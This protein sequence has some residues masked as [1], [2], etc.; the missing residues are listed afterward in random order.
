[1]QQSEELLTLLNIAAHGHEQMLRLYLAKGGHPNAVIHVNE[2]T[3]AP[4]DTS[5][6]DARA[7]PEEVKEWALL[8]YYCIQGWSRQI[9]ILLHANADPNGVE[10][11]EPPMCAAA[12]RGR[13]DIMQLL[14]SRGAAVNCSTSEHPTPLMFAAKSG[15]VSAVSW[16][17][18][19]GAD[20][21]SKHL[22]P[23]K[24]GHLSALIWAT[25]RGHLDV[26]QYLDSC[27]AALSVGTGA[28]RNTALHEA[29]LN[30]QFECLQYVLGTEAGRD[31]VHEW[32]WTGCTPLQVAAEMS[33]D[34]R[35]ISALIDAGSD[36]N[37]QD[38]GHDTPLGFAVFK[39]KAETV[40]VLCNRGADVM[41]DNQ[42]DG[43]SIV[44]QGVHAG[45][46]KAVR[47]LMMSDAWQAL[48]SQQRCERE[49]TL[50][51]DCTDPATLKAVLAHAHD[52]PALLSYTDRE[53]DTALHMALI[54]DRSAA[55]VS[56]LLEAG[57][58]VTAE[59]NLDRTAVVSGASVGSNVAVEALMT[60]ATWQAL[61]RGKRLELEQSLAY[62]C[63]DAETLKVVLAHALDVPNMLSYADDNE[64]T[65]LHRAAR[66]GKP[67]PFVCM[68]LK[69]GADYTLENAYGLTP[70][71][72]AH[73]LGHCG[74]CRDR[75]ARHLRAQVAR[76]GRYTRA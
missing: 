9:V 3:L 36:I 49:E 4:F 46:S 54:F 11:L 67:A 30:S 56:M 23:D 1:M 35:I 10:G 21:N 62:C 17:C 6:A 24:G 13:T 60:A 75:T 26:L 63:K 74:T 58:D 61:T 2:D 28:T 37:A 64:N 39:N 69:A 34:V 12:E 43:T 14:L 38:N 40:R 25:Y 33:D 45:C 53:G 66:R 19:Q 42:M 48:T 31:L 8:T 59:N 20:I 44:A 73:D 7:N 72:V 70:A 41:L 47:A 65:A 22:M 68:L 15:H 51:H 5:T 76:I 50:A 71:D 18:Q 57:A 16:L 27:G 32:N 52:V 29:A 55:V